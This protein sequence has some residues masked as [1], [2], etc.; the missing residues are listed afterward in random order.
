MDLFSIRILNQFLL[1]D[2]SVSTS[3][4]MDWMNKPQLDY[5]YRTRLIKETL[6]KINYTVRNVLKIDYEVITIKKSNLD[7]RLRVYT[8]DKTLFLGYP[9][10]KKDIDV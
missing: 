5:S 8:I 7:K 1:S 9:T 2:N 6:Y 10:I 4:I 3:E